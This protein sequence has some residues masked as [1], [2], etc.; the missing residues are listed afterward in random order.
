MSVPL[1][2]DLLDSSLDDAGRF[3]VWYL[4]CCFISS[5]FGAYVAIIFDRMLSLFCQWLG[6]VF[7]N[8]LLKR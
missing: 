4:G 6:S 3:L 7:R 8:R 5:L 2:R 1:V